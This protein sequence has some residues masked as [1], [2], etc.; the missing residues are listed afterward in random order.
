MKNKTPVVGIA[1]YEVQDD[2]LLNEAGQFSRKSVHIALSIAAVGES[3]RLIDV[4]EQHSTQ[5]SPRAVCHARSR[6][7]QDP[8]LRTRSNRLEINSFRTKKSS[9][10]KSKLSMKLSESDRFRLVL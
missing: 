5:K 7:V 10:G 2:D 1:K 9:L 4:S 8:P 6:A 3:F